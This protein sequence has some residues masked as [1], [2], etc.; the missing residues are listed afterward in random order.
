MPNRCWLHVLLSGLPFTCTG[1]L[2]FLHINLVVALVLHIQR[3]RRS[4]LCPLSLATDFALG[5]KLNKC[6]SRFKVEALQILFRTLC[7]FDVTS[8]KIESITEA[9][10]CMCSYQFYLS[11]RGLFIF[12]LVALVIGP[13]FASLADLLKAVACLYYS[14]YFEVCIIHTWLTTIWIWSTPYRTPRTVWT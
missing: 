7:Q 13:K 6:N 10:V 12:W 4:H 11:V 2:F 8:N 5:E 9:A 1:T 3:V 14:D